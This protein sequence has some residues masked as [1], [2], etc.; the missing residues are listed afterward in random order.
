MKKIKLVK[1][2]ANGIDLIT[3]RDSGNEIRILTG[4]P[5]RSRVFYQKLKKACDVAL[6][7]LHGVKDNS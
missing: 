3:E 4:K 2:F 1:N 7:S 6:A 5:S